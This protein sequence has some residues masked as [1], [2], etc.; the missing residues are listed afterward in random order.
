[1][2]KKELRVLSQTAL[3]LEG[4]G[5]RGAY[6]A[7]VLAFFHDAAFQF[8]YVIGTSAGACVATSYLSNQRDRNYEVFVNYASHP[9]YISYKRFITK[10]QLFGMDFI[11]DT[12]P[13]KLVPYDY[14]TFSKRTSKLVIGATDIYSGEPVYYDSFENK[15]ELLKIVRASSSLP[16]IAPSIVHNGLELMDGGISDPIPV[17]HSIEAGNDKHVVIL[18]RNEGYVK[19]EMKF[20]R[21]VQRKY[22]AYPGLVTA[23][24]KRHEKYN[25]TLDLLLEMEKRQEV[26]IVRPELPLVVDRIER[27]KQKLEALYNQGYEEAERLGGKIQTFLNN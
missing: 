12:I 15:Q 1:M 19:K 14:E 20:K 25:Q 26:F 9:E 18:T 23:M 16:F 22:K 8:P 6:T 7:G 24:L 11:F 3:I 21:F 27:N 10:R 5:M 2:N 4:G 13:N 17:T